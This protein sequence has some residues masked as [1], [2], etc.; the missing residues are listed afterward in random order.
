MTTTR[1][2]HTGEGKSRHNNH[3]KSYGYLRTPE[4]SKLVADFLA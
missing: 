3:H 4:F 1:D 2:Y